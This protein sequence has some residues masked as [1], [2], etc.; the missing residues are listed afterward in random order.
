MA[1]AHVNPKKFK[2]FKKKPS[3][4]KW[5]GQ[6]KGVKFFTYTTNNP[7]NK[8]GVVPKKGNQIRYDYD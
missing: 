4:G 2:I 6:T 8:I 5:A 3:Y 1:I 7:N